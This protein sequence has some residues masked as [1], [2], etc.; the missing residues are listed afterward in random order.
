MFGQDNYFFNLLADD[1]K[2]KS[3]DGFYEIKN[4]FN[5]IDFKNFF[6][7]DSVKRTATIA[8]VYSYQVE[9]PGFAKE[10]L[11]INLEDGILSINGKNGTRTVGHDIFLGEDTIDKVTLELGVLEIKVNEVRSKE[12]STKIKID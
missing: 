11:D 5:D 2:K 12:K 4:K 3:K 9:V 1:L 6:K 8:G 10:A 7:N